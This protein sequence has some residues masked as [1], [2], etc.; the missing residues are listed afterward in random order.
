M[1][2]RNYPLHLLFIFLVVELVD[3]DDVLNSKEDSKKVV[4]GLWHEVSLQRNT[5]DQ[6]I[7]V[8]LN[9]KTIFEYYGLTKDSDYS[10][11]LRTVREQNL[12]F[13]QKS[14]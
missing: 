10:T 14:I 9:E 3:G 4:D 8:K 2:N 7:R 11:N 13:R 1:C 12:I 6:S 5:S